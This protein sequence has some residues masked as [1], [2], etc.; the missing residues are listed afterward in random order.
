MEQIEFL[1]CQL[2]QLAAAEYFTGIQIQQQIIIFDPVGRL[3]RVLRLLTAQ[4]HA[5]PGQQLL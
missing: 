4:Q 3:G 2:Y 5:N 1:G